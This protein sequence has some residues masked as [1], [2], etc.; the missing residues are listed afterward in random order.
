[1]HRRW[2]GSLLSLILP[3]AGLY[4]SGNRNTGWT[5][6]L[7]LT[8]L[9]LIKLI[10]IPLSAI[11][12]LIGYAVLSL[13]TLA[14]YCV[15]VVRSYEHVP[16]IGAVGWIVLLSLAISLSFLKGPLAR[17]FT[18]PFKMP[19][20]SMS[21]T[22]QP[23]DHLFA[24]GSAYWFTQPNRGDVVV[25][26]TDQMNVPLLPKG[27]YYVK[28]IAALPG[29]TVEINEGRLVINGQ[30]ISTP[31]ILAKHHFMLHPLGQP[32]SILTNKFVVPINHYFVV[33]DDATNSYDSR[34]FGPIP[35]NAIYGKATKIYWPFD[36][37][38]DIQ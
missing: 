29:E 16:R 9:W 14:L 26:N 20:N 28:R 4:L 24:Q 21:P 33:G 5:W 32:S 19:T 31:A 6:F 30:P 36:H 35:R 7:G 2:V 1:M 3:G 38:A 12:N 25:F 18:H 17:Y 11:P 37:M 34:Y 23:G 22:I 27:Y 13:I 15:L 8:I 10:V